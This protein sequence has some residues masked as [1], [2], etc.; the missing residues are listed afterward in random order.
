MC[1]K[2]RGSRL[3]ETEAAHKLLI[4]YTP[5]S[6]SSISTPPLFILSS[7]LRYP[8]S[9]SQEQWYAPLVFSLSLAPLSN[10]SLSSLHNG[11]RH[12]CSVD[13]YVHASVCV[14]CGFRG[15]PVVET[16]QCWSVRADLH[17]HVRVT[18][19]WSILCME[20][21]VCRV[22]MCGGKVLL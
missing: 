9:L 14:F 20:Q 17:E 4:T 16:A 5:H 2:V 22:R 13:P 8:S 7:L 21:H 3:I 15:C 10:V 18:P 1:L 6:P 19:L 11:A 12:W